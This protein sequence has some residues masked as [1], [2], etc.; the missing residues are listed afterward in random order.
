M[1]LSTAIERLSKSHVRVSVD[2]LSSLLMSAPRQDVYRL[3]SLIVAKLKE[4]NTTSLFILEEGM[5]DQQTV[6][7]L[8]QLLDS[9]VLFRNVEK[10]GFLRKEIC[11]AKMKRT[12]FES[13]WL[14]IARDPKTGRLKIGK[15]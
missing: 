15:E 4:S 5:H 14:P 1:A 8:Q 2:L 12:N 3:A 9:V 13:K 10:Q 6:A 7:S 11:V